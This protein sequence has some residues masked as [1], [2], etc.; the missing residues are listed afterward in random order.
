MR[1]GITQ[2]HGGDLFG[3]E[4]V[5]ADGADPGTEVTPDLFGT[6]QGQVLEQPLDDEAALDM[7]VVGVEFAADSIAIMGGGVVEVLILGETADG[8]HR[9]HPEVVGIGSDGAQSLLEGNLNF[10]A[11]GIE[12]QDF[13]FG[14]LQVGGH[15][16]DAS[17]VRMDDQDKA[18][19]AAGGVPQ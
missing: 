17:T 19:Q 16:D 9:L 14:Q 5:G 7:A 12:A 1:E 11:Q 4:D 6:G 13:Q 3:G 10:E 18:H 2:G 15:K 8:F